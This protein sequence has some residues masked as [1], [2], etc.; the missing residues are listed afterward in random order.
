MAGRGHA[1][2]VYAVAWILIYL[3]SLQETLEYLLVF[4]DHTGVGIRTPGTLCAFPT[5]G[6]PNLSSLSK[7]LKASA[8]AWALWLGTSK[9]VRPCSTTSGKPP[10]SVAITGRPLAIAS[11]TTFGSPSSSELKANTL[12][13]HSRGRISN[14]PDIRQIRSPKAACPAYSEMDLRLLPSPTIHNSASGCRRASKSKA[15]IRVWWSFSG[16]SR[17]MQRTIFLSFSLEIGGGWKNAVLTPFGMTVI[18]DSGIRYLLD[19]CLFRA[20]ALQIWWSARGQSSFSCC[21]KAEPSPGRC[22]Q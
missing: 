11:R 10:T 13:C 15:V 3:P 4:L 1:L 12:P 22:R 21:R 18:N 17:A 20:I 14:W 2:Q 6:G 5:E 8:R 9:P 7:R 19:S 16:T